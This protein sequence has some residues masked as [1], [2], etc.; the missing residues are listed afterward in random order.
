MGSLTALEKGN[1]S[2]TPAQPPNAHRAG[3]CSN[4]QE[5]S[6]DKSV[7]P[8]GNSLGGRGGLFNALYILDRN[9]SSVVFRE[10]SQVVGPGR[11]TL[12]AATWINPAVSAASLPVLW[13]DGIACGGDADRRDR[14]HSTSAP[15]SFKLKR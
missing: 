3:K 2:N 15:G 11:T 12:Q 14:L 1:P 9:S 10:A 13:D 7:S 5:L 4:P 8:G 6:H